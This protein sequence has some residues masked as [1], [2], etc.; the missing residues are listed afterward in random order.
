M[1]KSIFTNRGNDTWIAEIACAIVF[2]IFTFAYLFFYQAD[3][4]TMEQHVLSDGLTKYNRTIGAVIITAILLL[5]QQGVDAAT[6]RTI[7]MPALT[8]F[9]PAMLLAMLTDIS[10]SIDHGYSIGK[11]AWLAPLL[12]T[13]WGGAAYVSARHKDSDSPKQKTIVQTIWE[14]ILAMS[15]LYIFIGA[16]ANTDRV[17]HERMKME[18]MVAEGKYKDA[19]NVK[20]SK[21]V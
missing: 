5:L 11:W 8:Y 10:P 16:T 3:L 21:T 20:T 9:P 19:L 12:L 6:K 4:L 18:V 7:K 1:T 2:C 15:A 13:A 17:F 14:N